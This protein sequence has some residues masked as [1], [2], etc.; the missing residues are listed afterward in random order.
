MLIVILVYFMSRITIW[1]LDRVSTNYKPTI[2]QGN[3]YENIDQ[4][5]LQQEQDEY[6]CM[7]E[8]EIDR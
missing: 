3:K 4:L 1:V 8:V 6:E 2:W 5:K 7:S